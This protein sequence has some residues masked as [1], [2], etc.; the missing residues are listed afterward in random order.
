MP[1]YVAKKG[2]NF[3]TA[4]L[5]NNIWRPLYVLNLV[6]FQVDTESVEP[7]FTLLED[8]ALRVRED[9]VTEGDDRRAILSNAA[10]TEEDY[11]VAPPGNIPLRVEEDKYDQ[12]DKQQ[13]KKKKRRAD[14]K[15]SKAHY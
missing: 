15:S 5:C 7:L 14:E 8:E 3:E 2:S 4:H 1:I 9:E 12:Q 11:F 10:V 6:S 13:G